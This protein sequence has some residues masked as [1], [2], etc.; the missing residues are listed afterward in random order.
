MNLAAIFRDVDQSTAAIVI[1]I[2]F[3]ILNGFM[4]LGLLSFQ[5][6]YYLNKYDCS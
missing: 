1:L 5:K 4:S 2:C 3:T 6:L